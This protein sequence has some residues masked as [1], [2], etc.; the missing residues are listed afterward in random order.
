VLAVVPARLASTRL[1]RKMLLKRTGSYLFAHTAERVRACAAIQRVVVAVDSP[2]VLAAAREAGLEAV[3][4]RPEHPSGTDRVHEAAGLVAAPPGGWDV[5]INVQGDEPDV[6]PADLA[7]LVHA[8][9]DADVVAATPCAPIA[10]AALIASPAVVKVVRDARGDALYFSR[11]PIPARTHARD[12]ESK[13][14]G[15]L[16]HVG[17]Y[18]WR[19][20]AL[21]RFCALGPGVLERADNLEQLRWLEA[22][23]RMRTVDAAHVPHSVDTQE[24][25][26]RFAERVAAL[27]RGRA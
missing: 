8:F 4:T 12:A 2:E 23:E 13:V 18:A 24:D 22:G 26:D 20:A 25:Y 6:D 7:R 1:P 19:P 21:A 16:R 14:A 17:V 3:M 11:A 9:A 15:A 5:V 27:Q 10:D